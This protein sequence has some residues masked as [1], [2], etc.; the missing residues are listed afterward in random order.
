MTAAFVSTQ[1]Q[2]VATCNLKLTGTSLRVALVTIPSVPSLPT[3]KLVRSNLNRAIYRPT[4]IEA[5]G[6]GYLTQ[7]ETFASGGEFSQHLRQQ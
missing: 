6:S 3:I 1:H 7:S 4:V 2:S 5:G